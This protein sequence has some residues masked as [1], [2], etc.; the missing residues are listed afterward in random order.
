MARPVRKYSS[1]PAYV[2]ITCLINVISAKY[3]YIVFIVQQ[4]NGHY[5]QASYS[6]T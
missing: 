6:N 1:S 5:L 2:Y 3:K 4:Y